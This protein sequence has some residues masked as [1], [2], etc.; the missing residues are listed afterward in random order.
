MEQFQSKPKKKNRK[1]LYLLLAFLAVFIVFIYFIT[2]PSLQ[3]VAIRELQTCFNTEDVKQCW[4]KYKTEL[5]QDEEF[6]SETRNKLASFNLSDNDIQSCKGWLPPPPT[7]INLIIVPDL[8]K[9]IIDTINN[10]DQVKN[11]TILLNAIWKNF[12]SQVRLK[13]DSKDRLVLDVTDEGQAGGSFRTIANQLIFDLSEHKNKSNRLYFDNIG[14]R[15]SQN[16]SKLYSLAS[17]DPIGADYHY[18]FEQRLPKLIKK[19]TLKDNYRNIL[20]IVT[21][22]YLESEK[23]ERTGI[24]AYTGTFSE[25][26]NVSNQLKSGKS[27]SEALSLIRPIPDCP[28]HFTDLEVLVIE[29]NPRAKRSAQEPND[30]GTVHDLTIM[31]SQWSNWFRMIG[32]KNIESE[33]FIRRNDATDITIKQ[34]EE[35]LNK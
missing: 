3:S 11:D 15:F 19:S 14:N 16:V 7:S 35:F 34:I 2:R 13:M 18:Y 28:T 8:S 10:P 22:G 24:W 33:F 5:S 32:I 23:A 6:V 9:R 12:V 25:R 27:Y 4:Y 31:K 29:V 26:T 20:L 1:P 30:P 17:K 21:D